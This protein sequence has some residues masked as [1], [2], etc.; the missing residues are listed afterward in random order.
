MLKHKGLIKFIDAKKQM[1]F[2]TPEDGQSKDIFF[3]FR[4]FK[5]DCDSLKS[6]TPV[7]FVLQDG[8]AHEICAL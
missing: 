3:R 5:G 1:G 8:E 6:G 2:I 7:V 4:A